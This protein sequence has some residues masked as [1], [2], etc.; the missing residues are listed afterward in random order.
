ML[1]SIAYTARTRA[2]CDERL[3]SRRESSVHCT[4]RDSRRVGDGSKLFDVLGVLDVGRQARAIDP[5][6]CA[7]PLVERLRVDPTAEKA[8]A[9]RSSRKRVA[10]TAAYAGLGDTADKRS[11][12]G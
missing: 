3:A 7:H 6:R 10:L 5:M 9:T 1:P 11:Q 2:T 8:S 4:Q 12:S